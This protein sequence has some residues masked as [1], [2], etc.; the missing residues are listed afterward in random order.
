MAASGGKRNPTLLIHEALAP[1]SVKRRQAINRISTIFLTTAALLG[2]LSGAD[3]PHA[4]EVVSVENLTPR[5]KRIGFLIRSDSNFTFEPGQFLSLQVPGRYVAQW[6]KRYGTSHDEAAVSRPYSLASA[7]RRLPRFD[8]IIGHRSAPRG[9]DVPP[10]LASTYVHAALRPGDV[11][12]FGSPIGNLYP[13][14]LVETSTDDPLIFVAGGTGAAPF[15]GV[16]EHWFAA[17]P[18]HRTIYLYLGVR[19]AKDLLLHERLLQWEEANPSFRYVP[20]L[21]RPQPDDFWNGETG[22]IHTVL[23]RHFSAPL[24]ADVSIAG[25]PIMIRETIKVLRAKGLDAARI[26]H[27]LI[28]G[29]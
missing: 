21:S 7:P 6:N 22:Y 3:S 29:R 24:S 16:L 14:A 28:P 20:A 26:R 11:V 25:P 12:R 19:A 18:A 10:G 17:K 27:D 4:A 2:A 13:R 5:V 9:K 8:L 23:D 1:S 15:V